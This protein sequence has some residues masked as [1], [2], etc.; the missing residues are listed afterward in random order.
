MF[1]KEQKHIFKATMKI[2]A[3][4]IIILTG[5]IQQGCH[6]CS[7]LDNQSLQKQ[8]TD[9][10][11]HIPTL[12]STCCTA[13]RTYPLPAPER[14]DASAKNK[15]IRKQMW[16]ISQ[17]WLLMT[18]KSA[19]LLYIL[20][21]RVQPTYSS[22]WLL[23]AFPPVSPLV[24][25]SQHFWEISILP[26]DIYCYT[27]LTQWEAESSHLED[28]TSPSS[29][30]LPKPTIVTFA[31]TLLYSRSLKLIWVRAVFC[32]IQVLPAFFFPEIIELI[33]TE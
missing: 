11:F 16:E 33:L 24:R 2:S 27:W 22:R 31:P 4:L 1:T 10:D 20:S 12:V 29:A 17:S 8:G 5:I 32:L 18:I 28:K 25:T 21:R 19:I 13:V 14:N 15:V 6:C 30:P 7:F 3:Y 9:K 26:S 23:T